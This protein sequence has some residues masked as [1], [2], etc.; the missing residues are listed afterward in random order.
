MPISVAHLD[1]IKELL[2]YSGNDFVAM[3]NIAGLRPEQDFRHANL[4][5]VDFGT[6]DTTG[7][8]FTGSDLSGADLSR[9]RGEP[10]LVTG[11]R[12]DRG[13]SSRCPRLINI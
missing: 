1:I 6:A 12:T 9:T 11:A 13:G 8:D 7:W 4:R 3:A 2:E 10:P 5:D